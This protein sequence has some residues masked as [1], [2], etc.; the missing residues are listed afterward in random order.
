MTKNVTEFMQAATAR[1]FSLPSSNQSF[2]YLYVPVQRRIPINQLR[3]RLRRLHINSSRIL[4]I[5]YPD[6]HFVALLIRNDYE[7]EL[8]SQLN[9]LTITVCDEYDPLDP[10]NLHR[11]DYAFGT[12]T[13]RLIRAV[14]RA[15]ARFFIEK[16]FFG[17]EALYS[18]LNKEYLVIP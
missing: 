4:D 17:T 6:R 8:R 11:V 10:A 14:Q 9:K 1:T 15:V 13:D 12:L 5:H 16:D 3:S 7:S 2:K 18:L